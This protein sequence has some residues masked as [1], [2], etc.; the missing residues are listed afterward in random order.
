MSNPGTK[1]GM[2]RKIEMSSCETVVGGLA[3]YGILNREYGINQRRLRKLVRPDSSVR[4]SVHPD[5]ELLT[6]NLI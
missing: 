3:L 1:S 4:I 2:T 6:Y 5:N